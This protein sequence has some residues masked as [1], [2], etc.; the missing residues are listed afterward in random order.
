[1]A[2]KLIEELL[3]KVKQQGAKPT[4]KAIK[5]V[6]EALDGA[7]KASNS[8]GAAMDSLPKR[9]QRVEAAAEKTANKLSKVKLNFS[10]KATEKSLSTIESGMESLLEETVDMNHTMTV[11]SNNL[12]QLFSNLATDLGADLERVEDG[13]IDVRTEAGKT[14]IT[15]LK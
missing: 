13:L 5:G 6:G 15:K 11:M 3:I 14:Y 4:E 7:K 2:N 8:F 9:L 12:I 1:M 10:S